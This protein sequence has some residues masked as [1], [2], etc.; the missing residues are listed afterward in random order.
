MMTNRRQKCFCCVLLDQL[1]SQ[2]GLNQVPVMHGSWH[3]WDGFLGFQVPML[4]WYS[5][6]FE[7]SQR[8]SQS[9]CL[10]VWNILITIRSHLATSVIDTPVGQFFSLG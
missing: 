5:P 9:L 10:G 8:N 1:F 4:V 7:I 6:H 3:Q 2:P